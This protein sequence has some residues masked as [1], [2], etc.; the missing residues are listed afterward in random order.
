MNSLSIDKFSVNNMHSETQQKP[1][2]AENYG[3]I[4]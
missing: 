4:L 2:H 1:E 3:E